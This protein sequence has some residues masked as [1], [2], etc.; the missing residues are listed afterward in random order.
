MN[1]EKK[2]VI[3]TGAS[4]GIGKSLAIHA[5]EKGMKVVLAARSAEKMKDLVR[6]KKYRK[7][8]Y[9]VVRCDVS[10]QLD[11]EHLIGITIEKFGKIDILINNAGISMRA[12]FSELDLNVLK[13]LMD[14]NFWGTVY[15]THYALPWL[16]KSKGS[17]VGVSSVAGFRGLPARTGYSASKFAMHGFFESLRTE[18]LHNGLHV[19]LACPGFTASNIRKNAFGKNG[20]IQGE[21]PRNEHT[22]MQPNEVALYIFKA[23]EK[24]KRNLVLTRQ[25]KITLWMNKLFPSITDKLVYNHMAREEDSPISKK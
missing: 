17:V 15:C 6:D 24:R 20:N 3:I 11:C 23:I 1:L 13:K 19:L 5:F 2:V 16:L 10:N 9:L 21:S 4:S 7:E 8:D 18:N 25:G 12:I 22:M 14:V